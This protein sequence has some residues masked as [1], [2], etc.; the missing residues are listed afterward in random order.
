MAWKTNVPTQTIGVT[1]VTQ[2]ALAERSA[3]AVRSDGTMYA[4]GANQTG[5][6]GTGDTI[7]HPTAVIIPNWT[8]VTEVAVGGWFS[9]AARKVPPTTES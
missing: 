3:L 9:L 7:P 5:Q 8:G 1:S 6:L 2:V 4:W